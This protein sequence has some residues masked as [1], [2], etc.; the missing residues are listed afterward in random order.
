MN[1]WLLK[2]EPDCFSIA[3]LM[4][5]PK[6]TTYWDGVR[7]YQARNFMRDGMKVGDRVLFYHSSCDPPGVAGL[8]VIAR[9][10]YPD[11]TAWDKTNDHFDPKASEENPIWLMVDVKFEEA[12]TELVPINALRDV[13]ALKN[14][15]LLRKGSRLSVQPVTAAEFDAVLKVADQLGVR[16]RK[17]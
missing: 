15:E 6:R 1:Y 4:A 8:A 10:A 7:N 3:D 17:K 5:C 12:F 9:E 13:P 16:K 14:M 2:S 11:F